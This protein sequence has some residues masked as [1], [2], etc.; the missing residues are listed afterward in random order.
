MSTLAT[1]VA[2]FRD[3]RQNRRLLPFLATVAEFGNSRRF[4][5]ATV[6]ELGDKLSP[7]SAT[8]VSSVDRP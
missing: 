5:L 6:A 3:C 1:V 7:K 2:Q 4:L 8:I